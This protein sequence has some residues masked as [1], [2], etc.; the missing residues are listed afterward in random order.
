MLHIKP[1]HFFPAHGLRDLDLESLETAPRSC[2]VPFPKEHCDFLFR[3]LLA[4][5]R[6]ETISHLS[7]KVCPV[8]TKGRTEWKKYVHTERT[9]SDALFSSAFPAP[10]LCGT[11]LRHLRSPTVGATCEETIP[12]TAVLPRYSCST[13][14]PSSGNYLILH[15]HASSC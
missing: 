9:V 4:A 6:R 10:S 2:K 11:Y 5:Y 12:T 14:H 1:H 3:N 7:C 8:T 15:Q 13:V